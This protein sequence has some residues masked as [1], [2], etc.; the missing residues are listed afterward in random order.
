MLNYKLYQEQFTHDV[1]SC[2]DRWPIASRAVPSLVSHPVDSHANAGHARALLMW[3]YN[4]CQGFGKSLI[5]SVTSASGSCGVIWTGMQGLLPG[6]I[7]QPGRSARYEPIE[8]AEE[9]DGL[10]QG[11]P[12]TVTGL[13]FSSMAA[14]GG[15]IE[16]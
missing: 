1:L 12:I 7:R 9:R 16:R 3:R 4:I 2:I 8:K 15:Q 14:K 5:H 6:E 13:S 10:D 11:Q